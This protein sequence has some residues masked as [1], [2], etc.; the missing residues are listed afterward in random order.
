MDITAPTRPVAFVTASPFSRA[1]FQ[2][3]A[4]VQQ[5]AT[6][7]P[8]LDTSTGHPMTVRPKNGITSDMPT[9]NSIALRGEPFASSL[10]SHRHAGRTSF[11]ERE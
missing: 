7:A 1:N 6:A 2:A 10:P 4:D 5:Y 9:T 3:A 11:A 8:M